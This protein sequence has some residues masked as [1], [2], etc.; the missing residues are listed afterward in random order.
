MAKGNLDAFPE[1]IGDAAMV[2]YFHSLRRVKS[3]SKR[4]PPI[5]AVY[6]VYTEPSIVLYVGQTVNLRQRWK[7][8]NFLRAVL[9]KHK[10]ELA[11][12]PCDLMVLSIVESYY[13]RKLR[14][15]LNKS[16]SRGIRTVIGPSWFISDRIEVLKS[17]NSPNV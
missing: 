13:I 17:Y 11:W 4:I 10:I 2:P 6:F 3:E 5:P 12:I 1:L 8:H 7:G 9:D 15:P 16:Q 14:P